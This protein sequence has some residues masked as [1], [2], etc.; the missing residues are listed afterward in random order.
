MHSEIF[1]TMNGETIHLYTLQNKNGISVNIMNYGATITSIKVPDSK[2]NIENIV[3]GFNNFEAYFSEEYKKNAPY[4]GSTVGRYCSQIKDAKFQL[5]G[6]EYT[7]A[8]N[9]GENNL[10]G[11]NIGFDKKI[12]KAETLN[13][14]GATGISMEILSEDLEEGFPGN[15]K[16]SVQFIL[17]DSNELSIEYSAVPDQDTPLS[18]T[19]HTYFNLNAFSSSVEN[20]TAQIKAGKKLVL[21]GTGAATGKIQPLE[22]R[23][24]DLREPKKIGE[25]HGKMNDGFEHYYI[26][27]KENFL[28]DKVAEFHCK[29]SGRSLGVAT[30][31]PGMLFYTGKYTSNELQRENGQEF[32]KYRGFCCETHRYPNGPNIQNSPKFITSAGEEFKSTTIFKFGW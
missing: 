23:P 17:N 2:G 6:K 25:V 30:K 27:D 32:G 5:H 11:G 8:K 13:L 20:H 1:G 14:K 18:L 3:C 22:G 31:E 12:W 26:F 9:A 4:F 28:S 10:H 16:V 29:K 21:D 24:D 7:L 15:V 19:N